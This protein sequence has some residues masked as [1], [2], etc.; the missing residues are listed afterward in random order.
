M[1]STYSWACSVCTHTND[2][3]LNY[4]E[5]CA[6]AA[7][8]NA[9]E[10]EERKKAYELGLKID[11]ANNH[12]LPPLTSSGKHFHWAYHVS[13]GKNAAAKQVANYLLISTLALVAIALILDYRQTALFNWDLFA[14][15]TLGFFAAFDIR[16]F[17]RGETTYIDSFP[18]AATKNNTSIRWVGLGLD[19]LMLIVALMIP[20]H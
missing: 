18:F 7:N 15:G 8:L 19:I 2:T 6:S 20:L 4:C 12:A 16:N 13:S 3:R 17:C 14:A 10:I 5:R 9:I 11:D 1:R